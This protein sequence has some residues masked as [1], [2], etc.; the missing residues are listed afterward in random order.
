MTGG[1]A[2]DESLSRDRAAHGARN[3]ALLERLTELGVTL[4]APRLIDCF[5]WAPDEA[6]ATAVAERLTER[7]MTQIVTSPPTD[8][9]DLW[10][11]Q[12]QMR[13]SPALAGS[14]GMTDTL[15]ALALPFGAEYDGW[16]T[17]VE[18]A[19]SKER[20]TQKEQAG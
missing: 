5:F 3:K 18:E 13:I 16:G 20:S 11:A 15:M 12:G 8:A 2:M 9:H 6:A 17:A 10:S 19:A 1:K 7:G 4:E 14:E